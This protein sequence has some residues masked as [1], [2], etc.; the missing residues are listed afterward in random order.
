[1]SVTAKNLG[2]AEH[3]RQ[4]VLTFSKRWTVFGP[5]RREDQAP[6]NQVATCPKTM[7]LGGRR[8]TPKTV[9]CNRQG[10]ADLAIDHREPGGREQAR[11]GQLTVGGGPPDPAGPPRPAPGRDPPGRQRQRQRQRQRHR[12]DHGR[13]RDP[14]HPDDR[15]R[16]L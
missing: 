15:A 5:C 4:G 10:V 13:Q 14:R 1:M 11:A 2:H 9:V 8:L 3:S 6:A 12:G 16:S 7:T